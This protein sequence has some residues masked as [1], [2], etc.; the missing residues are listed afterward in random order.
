MMV[1]S[2]EQVEN[3]LKNANDYFRVRPADDV[4]AFVIHVGHNARLSVFRRFN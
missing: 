1:V 2:H 3:Q 4:N